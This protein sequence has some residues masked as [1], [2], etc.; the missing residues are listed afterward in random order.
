MLWNF[1]VSEETLQINKKKIFMLLIKEDNKQHVERLNLITTN[2]NCHNSDW[3]KPVIIIPQ[4]HNGKLVLGWPSFMS[5]GQYTAGRP[6][7]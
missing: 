4:N 1:Q 7:H 2:S 5:D 6:T 3:T